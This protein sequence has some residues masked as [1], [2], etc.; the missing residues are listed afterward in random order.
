MTTQRCRRSNEVHDAVRS[1][2]WSDALDQHLDTC[3][4][5]LDIVWSNGI[6][7][8]KGQLHQQAVRRPA[9]DATTVWWKGRAAAR[10]RSLARAE[11]PFAVLQVA[12]LGLGSLM[13][14]A[15]AAWSLLNTP[16][17]AD[18][19]RESV[20]VPLVVLTTVM[21]ISSILSLRIAK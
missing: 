1:G 18:A 8:L 14:A 13:T 6:E 19:Q 11:R 12:C 4:I 10:A 20:A 15:I 2:R 21:T 3:D 9:L 7:D 16:V 5:C 17:V